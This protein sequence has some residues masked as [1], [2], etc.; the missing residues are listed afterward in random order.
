MT[1]GYADVIFDAGQELMSALSRAAPGVAQHRMVVGV[2][3]AM[4]K[5]VVDRLLQPLFDHDP[6]L[7][8][9]CE[10]ARLQPLLADLAIHR[11]DVVLSDSPVPPTVDVKAFNHLLGECGVSLLARP[12][13]AAKVREHFPANMNDQPLILPT[14]GSAL[15]RTL[16]AWLSEHGVHCRTVA[17]VADSALIKVM[18]GRGL[19]MFAVP[20]V[21]ARDVCQRFDV[22]LI[23]HVPQVREKFYAIS[24]ERR[25]R[26]AGVQLI[27]QNARQSMFKADDGITYGSGSPES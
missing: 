10:E 13:L 15:R 26:H 20:D 9:V 16:D 22:E 17:E 24:T 18:G 2:T 5:T 7:H 21:I 23:G 6:P 11:I 14:A 12:D 8:V 25:L 4:P 3:E 19:G 1:M 27:C